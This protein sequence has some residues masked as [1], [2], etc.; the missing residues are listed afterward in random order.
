MSK[1]RYGDH[2]VIENLGI[3]GQV[4]EEDTRSVIVRYRKADG[5]LV[6]HRFRPEELQD[7]SKPHLE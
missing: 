2:V 5:E 7:I 4:I 6:E 3:D 1:L